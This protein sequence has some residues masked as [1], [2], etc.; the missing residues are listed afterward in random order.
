MELH[1]HA[2]ADGAHSLT[3]MATDV[4]GNVSAASAALSVTVDTATAQPTID[5]DALSDTGSS[6]S[7]NLTK[8]NTPS[9]SGTAEAGSTV[10]IFDGTT[11]LGTVTANGSGAWSFTSTTL[12]DGVHSLTAV[13]TDVAG[14]VSAASAAL[15]VTVDTATAQ[16]TIDLDA[17]SDTGSSDSDNRPRTTRRA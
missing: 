3:A 15:S 10:E 9:L 5:L 11:S 6:D 8:D 13:A 14:N 4:A 16:P 7:D 2:L 12:A 1:Q 17:L